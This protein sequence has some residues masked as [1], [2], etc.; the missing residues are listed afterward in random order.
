LLLAAGIL[1]VFTG[2]L[3]AAPAARLALSVVDA[4]G[5][6][7]A[8]RV[9]VRPAGGDCL[10]PDGATDLVIGP[11]RWFMSAGKVELDVPVGSLELRVEHGLEYKRIKQTLDVPHRG[12]TRTLRPERWIDMHKLGYRCGENHT[13]VTSPIYVTVGGRGPAVARSI[14]EARRMLDRFEQFA[15]RTASDTYRPALRHAVAEARS[16]LDRTTVGP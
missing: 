1:A 10:V 7:L 9:L 15:A 6:P 12:L 16:R 3:P 5:K 14:A 4:S 13:H 2:V 11:D 8:C